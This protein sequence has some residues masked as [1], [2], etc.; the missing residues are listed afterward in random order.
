ML[1]IS[2]VLLSMLYIDAQHSMMHSHWHN[3]K[4]PPFPSKFPLHK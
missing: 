2:A 1:F 3:D 4:K